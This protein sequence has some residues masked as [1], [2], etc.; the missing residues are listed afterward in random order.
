M[1][2]KRLILKQ[3]DVSLKRFQPLAEVSPPPKGWIFAIRFALG[4]SARQL[5]SRLG[6]TQQAV[7]RIE[8]AETGGAVTIKTLRKIAEQLDCVFV[9]GIVPRTS[10]EETVRRQAR[11]TAASRLKRVSN[12][13]DLERQ[14]L[15]KEENESMLNEMIDEIVRTLPPTLWD[16]K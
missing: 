10:L 15:S 1:D 9:Y 2:K 4:M 6:I 5:A 13:M 16:R 12:T 3:L 8:N 14:G 7:A 11:V